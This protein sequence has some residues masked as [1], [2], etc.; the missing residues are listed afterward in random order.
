MTEIVKLSR[1][2]D[3]LAEIWDYIADDGETQADLFIDTITSGRLRQRSETATFSRA[4]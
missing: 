2:T 4:A 1:A 3:D